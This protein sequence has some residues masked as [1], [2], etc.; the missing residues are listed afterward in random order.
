MF[1]IF[2]VVLSFEFIKVENNLENAIQYFL[3]L[4]LDFSLSALRDN[5]SIC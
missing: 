2:Y 4:Q 1:K 3:L 5:N